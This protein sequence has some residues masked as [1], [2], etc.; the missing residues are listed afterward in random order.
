MSKPKANLRLFV[1]AYPPAAVAQALLEEL[2]ALTLPAHRTTPADQVHLTVHFIG[3]TP[4]ARMERTMESIECAVAGLDSVTL[5]PRRLIRLPERGPARLIAAEMEAPPTL[6]ELQRRLVTRL[7]RAPR[8]R[9]ADRFR[10]HMTLCRFAVPARLAPLDHAVSVGV[11]PVEEIVLM[12]S[13]LSH[14]GAVHHPVRVFA[15]KAPRP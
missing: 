9:T 3:D 2:A 10:P 5:E 7:A 13:T 8:R 4:A 1:A 11:M 15:L 6:R 12:R 14:R